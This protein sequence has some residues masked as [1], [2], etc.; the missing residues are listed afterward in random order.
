MPRLVL[1]IIFLRFAC[2]FSR[3]EVQAWFVVEFLK[4]L[5]RHFLLS[6]QHLTMSDRPRL[7]T[8]FPKT[9]SWM[10]IRMSRVTRIG[11]STGACAGTQDSQ[12]PAHFSGPRPLLCKGTSATARLVD[13]RGW[14]SG[15]SSKV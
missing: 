15:G 1:R 6:I 4:Y 5:P 8:S 9:S 2:R 13:A 3:D 11:P 10:L 7:T 14:H 12:T